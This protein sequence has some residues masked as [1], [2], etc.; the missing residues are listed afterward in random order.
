MI[1]TQIYLTDRQRNELAAIA[2]TVGKKQ[3]ELIREAIDRLIAQEGRTHREALLRKTLEISRHVL[4]DNHPI[5]FD[6]INALGVVLRKQKQYEDAERL[7]DN[8]LEGR[9]KILGEDHP[10]T[11]DSK[12]DLAVLNKEQGQHEEAE[13]LLIEAVKGRRLKLSDTHPHTIESW[14]NLIELYEVWGKPEEAE[15]WRAKLPQTKAME[16]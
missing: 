7:F 14:K 12:N 6:Y 3:S 10:S 4:G 11:L 5:T 2:K 1:R 15:K 13:P 9:K 8:A 16:E